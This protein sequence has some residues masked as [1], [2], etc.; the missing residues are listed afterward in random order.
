MIIL[1]AALVIKNQ[2][3]YNITI[4]WGF[5]ILL[6]LVGIYLIIRSFRMMWIG[7]LLKK[8]MHAVDKYIEKALHEKD[9][10]LINFIISNS[11]PEHLVVKYPF[12]N[13]IWDYKKMIN[14]YSV[15]SID[16]MITNKELFDKIYKND[17]SNT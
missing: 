9:P 8:H 6:F 17:S 2:S 5:V 15:W 16:K 14:N 11:S 10:W 3:I 4:Y 13:C 1:S 7:Y 12:Y